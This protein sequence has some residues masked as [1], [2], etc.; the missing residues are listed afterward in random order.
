MQRRLA[1][2]TLILGIA[3]L[4]TACGFQ[5]RG[6]GADLPESWK[7]MYMV[8]G[9]PNGEFSQ[10]VRSVF[11]TNGIVWTDKSDTSYSFILGPERFN[12]ANLS[13]NNE[14]RVSQ[15]ELTLQT[16]FSVRDPSGAEVMP[17]T[18]ATVLRQMENDPRN[19]LGMG[20]ELRILR[21]EM[22]TELAQQIIRRIGFFSTSKP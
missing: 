15:Y 22:N 16:T 19:A 21:A 6:T 14:A 3:C 4:L 7:H 12:Q 1:S 10:A 11:T 2:Y 13:L 9:N 20:E 18:T 8:T 5:L 17:D